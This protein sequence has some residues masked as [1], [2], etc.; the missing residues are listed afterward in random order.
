MSDLTENK[1]LS[2]TSVRYLKLDEEGFFMNDEGL[3]L[4]D[5]NWG[6][7]LLERV[8]VKDRGRVI[9]SDASGEITLEAFDEPLV[10]KQVMTPDHN[11]V[12]G[13]GKIWSLVGN[14]QFRS[15]FS[16][17]KLTLDEWD[18]FHGITEAG[19]PFVFSR[20]AQAEFFRLLDEFE[21]EAIIYNEQ[22]YETPNYFRETAEAEQEDFWA[23]KYKGEEAGWELNEPSRALVSILPT[24]KLQK[25]RVL[26]LG[27][28]SG[29][30]ANHFAKQGHLVTAVDFSDEAIRRAK[31]K[32]PDSPVK[33]IKGDLF[34]MGK[35]FRNQF[36][37]V[38]EHA[39][40]AAIPPR[41]RNELIQIWK[42]ALVPRGYLLG[43]LFTMNQR[44]GPPYGGSEWEF[45]ERLKGSFEFLIWRRWRDSIEKRAGRELIVLAQPI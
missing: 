29:E 1:N 21:D 34:S 24:I 23:S 16:I 9:T 28:G 41:R 45:R 6:R 14:Y 26:V 44:S 20:A 10:V 12:N 3:R 35:E 5:A 42:Q 22:R 11:A 13:A 40:L 30:D 27:C 4:D 33:W 15:T 7:S 37:V 2:P 39:C 43:I 8:V 19:I 36:D 25:S 32:F 18:R 31:D 38:F 17:E